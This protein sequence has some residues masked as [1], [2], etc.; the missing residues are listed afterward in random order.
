MAL[1]N[2]AAVEA[3]EP[4]LLLL[5][6]LSQGHHEQQDGGEPWRIDGLRVTNMV[7]CHEMP[8]SVHQ[9]RPAEWFAH[10]YAGSG[11]CWDAKLI[12]GSVCDVNS[13]QHLLAIV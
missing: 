5:L 9:E 6:A 4:T 10:P 12:A 8:G 2:G 3:K 13:C 11:S 1:L 7:K